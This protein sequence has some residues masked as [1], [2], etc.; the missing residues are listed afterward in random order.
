MTAGGTPSPSEPQP[1]VA[2]AAALFGQHAG[3]RELLAVPALSLGVFVASPGEVDEQDPHD[4]DE[5]YVILDGEAV[6]DIAGVVHPVTAGSVAY[7]PAGV[8]H[9][10]AQ[11]H[12]DLRVLVFFAGASL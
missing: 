1:W 4:R 10:F 2:D 11:V 5:V 12:A 3:Y 8:D 7:V 9:H 6:L